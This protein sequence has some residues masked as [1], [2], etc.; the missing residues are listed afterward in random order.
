[1]SAAA[2]HMQQA[3][4]KQLKALILLY[5]EQPE[6]THNIVKL[7]AKCVQLGAPVPEE[8]DEISEMLTMWETASRYDPFVVFSEKNIQR[9]RPYTK[10]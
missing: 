5:G 9:L 2:Y 4:E 10:I 3:I 7:T 1:M 6:F 8:L